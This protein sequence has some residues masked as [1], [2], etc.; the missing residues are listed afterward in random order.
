MSPKSEVGAWMKVYV[1]D[2]LGGTS[3]MTPLEIGVYWLLL[4]HGWD[5]SGIP[6][7][8]VRLAII[9]RMSLTE[10]ES[11]WE[12][13][14]AKKFVPHPDDPNRLVN[15]KQ[16]EVRGSQ[17]V[18]HRQRVEAGHS[19]AKARKQRALERSSNERSDE[20]PNGEGED[21]GL[22]AQGSGSRAKGPGMGAT[23]PAPRRRRDGKQELVSAIAAWDAKHGSMRSDLVE[24]LEKYRAWRAASKKSMW[25]VE[26]WE[27]N[28]AQFQGDQ[29]AAIEAFETSLRSGWASVHPQSH[30]RAKPLTAQGRTAHNLAD[31]REGLRRVGGGE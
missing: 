13:V 9:A 25:S 23:A 8:P 17:T 7:S 6:A 4:L 20:R 28:L 26:Q 22:R 29:E 16:E 30:G 14:L 31:I 11:L 21:S 18:L 1:D 5:N 19:S 27:S 10:F 24:L 15:E 2:F 3:D 12:G